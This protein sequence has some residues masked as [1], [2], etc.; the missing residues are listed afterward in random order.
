MKKEEQQ[1]L[2]ALGKRIG[3][4]SGPGVG[5]GKKGTKGDSADKSSSKSPTDAS[6]GRSSESG[7]P[8]AHNTHSVG[9]QFGNKSS[10]AA[11]SSFYFACNIV[12]FFV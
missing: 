9:S 3:G 6:V 7:P 12:T 8:G 11:V 1:D 2:D 10:G 4:R 5:E